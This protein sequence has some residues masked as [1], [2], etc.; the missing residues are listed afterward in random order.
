ML[1]AFMGF[2]CLVSAL[3]GPIIETPLGR[4]EGWERSSRSG[5]T[6]QAW[7]KVP[8]AKPPIG[9]LR[10]KAP[11]PIGK[12]DGLMNATAH[13]TKCVQL[14]EGVED[15][16]YLNVYRPKG[17]NDKLPV[18]FYVHGGAFAIGDPGVREN[19]DYLMDEDIVLVGVAYR[20]NGYGF[21][22]FGDKVLPGNY[23]L[24]DQAM[25]LAWVNQNIASFGGDP[26]SI[27]V[28]GGSAGGA[29]AHYLLK[30]PLTESIVARAVSHSGTINH[31][32][33]IVDHQLAKQA[34]MNVTKKVK[35]LRPTSEEM[36]EC[37]QEVN[38]TVL[39]EA[40]FE[41]GS[42]K[43]LGVSL[44][45]IPI[46]EPKDVEGA[47]ATED[48]ALRPSKKPWI[49]TFTNGEFHLLLSQ[50][51]R[52]P[53]EY[54]T[55]LESNFAKYLTAFIISHRNG[56]SHSIESAQLLQDVYLLNTDGNFTINYAKMFMDYSFVYPA[57]FNLFQHEGPKWLSLMEYKG[58]LSGRDP[59]TG[60]QDP[61]PAAGHA[62]EGLYYFNTR[63]QYRTVGPNMTPDDLAVSKRLI[64]YLVNFA[65]Y[66]DPTPPGTGF[67]WP[68]FQNYEMIRV[69]ANGD[70]ISNGSETLKK[71]LDIWS[72]AIGWK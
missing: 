38:T 21:M 13:I 56:S 41:Y 23:G 42:P 29:S 68:R 62:D 31:V 24:K 63:S 25:A 36:L 35:C 65:K 9:K 45:F 54:N 32:W 8:Y 19:A 43:G 33:S 3:A 47:F 70:V 1:L 5:R 18:L 27:T 2:S 17:V 60:E 49:T 64:K 39:T 71:A 50:L 26:N 16:L 72:Y 53:Q 15:C 67:R 6:Y 46:I 61:F 7:T 37:L 28:F 20:L 22:S 40:I 57:L 48:L 34:A 52:K 12:H 11:V 69:T 14:S 58:E 55:D 4:Y 59:I 66:G 44:V 30:S 51:R 10:F